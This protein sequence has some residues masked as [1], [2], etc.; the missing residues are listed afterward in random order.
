M[1]E[2][3]AWTGVSADGLATLHARIAPRFRRRE[4]REAPGE[5]GSPA[6]WFGTGRVWMSGLG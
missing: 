3:A 4:A 6:G 2:T 5:A 1:N